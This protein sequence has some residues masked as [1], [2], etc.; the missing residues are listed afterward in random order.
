MIGAGLLWFGWFGFNAG[1]ALGANN[2]AAVVFANTLLA[3]CT[4]SLAWL[5]HRA[6]PRRAR[7]IVR[8]RL[9]GG[10]RS[11]CHHAVVRLGDPARR[12]G[13]RRRGRGDLRAG[14]R[15]EAPL[16]LRRLA[17]RGRGA[18]R[19]R[20]GRHDPDRLPASSVVTSVDGLLYG[21][22]AS[23]LGKQ[24]VACGAT[25]AFSFVVT[26]LLALVLDKTLGFRIDEEHEISGI[27]LVLHA[28]RPTTSR[29]RPVVGGH[30]SG[31]GQARFRLRT[32]TE[33]LMT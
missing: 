30:T 23:Q 16:R 19:R 12:D 21:G 27:D 28:R 31:L 7:H 25:F 26:Y 24:L 11:G 32:A 13:G 17:R 2:L 3:G 20:S 1:S 33:R 22:D 18:P 29:H 6:D 15:P 9:G 8:R 4:G 14:S 10:R 5:E